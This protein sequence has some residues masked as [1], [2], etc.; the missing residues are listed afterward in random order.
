[1]RLP[2]LLFPGSQQFM[3][4]LEFVFMLTY[5]CSLD[6]QLSLQ[7]CCLVLQLLL[8]LH[9]RKGSTFYTYCQSWT[10]LSAESFLLSVFTYSVGDY[11]PN[12][13]CFYICMTLNNLALCCTSTGP[14][15]WEISGILNQL[16]YLLS[17][18]SSPDCLSLGDAFLQSAQCSLVLFFTAAGLLQLLG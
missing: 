10:T 18:L 7:S 11:M 6:V 5:W 16:L 3:Q 8:P 2:V 15:Y 9:L 14:P 13:L 17:L 1:M 12:E 4:L